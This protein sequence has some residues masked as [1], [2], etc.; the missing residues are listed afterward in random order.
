MR[1]R[2]K[3]QAREGRVFFMDGFKIIRDDPGLDVWAD[4][5]TLYVTI[6][7]GPDDQAPVFGRGIL[8]IYPDDFKQQLQTLKVNNGR[9]LKQRARARLSFARVFMGTVFDTYVGAE[10]LLP[11]MRRPGGLRRVKLAWLGRGLA[12]AIAIGL[13]WWP[14][15]PAFLRQQP[16]IEAQAADFEVPQEI[17]ALGLFPQYLRGLDLRPGKYTIER[18]HLR[19]GWLNDNL[20]TDHGGLAGGLYVKP[21]DIRMLTDWP[22]RRGYLNL[23]RVRDFASREVVG[24]GSQVEMAT[25]PPDTRPMPPWHDIKADTTWSIA[26]AERG[27]LFLSQKEG[28]PDIGQ[29]RAEAERAGQPWRGTKRF[30][31]TLG[32]LPDAQ[33]IVHGGTGAFA[34]VVGVFR[35]WNS[36]FMVPPAGAMDGETEWEITLI[37][38][39]R[40]Q[41]ADQQVRDRLPPQARA[42]GAPEATLE[43]LAP[44]R[45]VRVLER[46]FEIDL[47]DD[48]IYRT[49]GSKVGGAVVPA[50]LGALGEASLAWVTAFMAR[51][52]DERSDV[53]GQ[54]GALR[55][56]PDAGVGGG[57]RTAQWTLLLGG[58]GSIFVALDGR[59]AGAPAPPLERGFLG[60]R[61]GVVVGGTGLYAGA[62]GDLQ[63][64]WPAAPGEAVRLRL[65]LVNDR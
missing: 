29:T 52:R 40:R 27:L 18:L 9:T 17:A 22:I 36:L 47:E 55:V 63:E 51:L 31:H 46:T 45:P 15:R 12:A 8:R 7:D 61:R 41:D 34:G 2:M 60:S 64:L 20:V 21:P 57:A 1:Y 25:L 59:D 38:A 53:V 48:I 37:R 42:L 30:N 5:T 50:S 65:R 49:H 28:G 14:W 56:E 10:R 58:E 13:A 4:T 19:A 43:R 24:L 11:E 39:P 23:A 16:Q 35:E 26:F 6:F 33:G 44:G 54:A 3:M 62:A 32:P